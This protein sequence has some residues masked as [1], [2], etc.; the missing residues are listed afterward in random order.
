VAPTHPVQRAVHAVLESM[1]GAPISDDRRATDNC[2]V[3]T[4][5]IS[6]AGLARAFACFGTGHGLAPARARGAERLRA[7]CAAKP[8]HVAGTGRFC[9]ELMQRFGPR[10]FAK[11]GAEG[12][13]CGALPQQGLGIAVKCDD[14]AGRAAEVAMAATVARFLSMD[15]AER[16][17]VES[18]VRPS[19]R[20]WNGS[21]VG[22]LRPTDV[23]TR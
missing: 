11:T 17:F 7:A 16:T 5:A 2:G 21:V 19:L 20:N 15:D 12:M 22:G 18:F 3:P 1:T 9:T 4:W 8:W 23:L 10:L 13:F 6:L 14:G